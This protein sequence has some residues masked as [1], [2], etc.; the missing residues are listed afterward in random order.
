[1]G[2]DKEYPNR[3]D[4]RK[5]YKDSRAVSAHC[6]NN[7][8]CSWCKGNRNYSNKKKDDSNKNQLEDL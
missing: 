7:G 3:K 5:P 1:M 6:R 8:S 4:K 2:F